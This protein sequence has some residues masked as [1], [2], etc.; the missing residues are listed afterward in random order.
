MKEL[1]TFDDTLAECGNGGLGCEVCKPVIHNALAS[2]WNEPV[3]KK[4]HRPL[5][6]SNDRYLANTQRGGSY[7]VIPRIPGGEILPHQLVAL[8]QVADKYGLY[9]K[10]S[11]AQRVVLFGAAVH[12]LPDIWKD[13]IDAGFESGHAYAKALRAVKS[14]VGSTWCRYGIG[15]SVGFAIRV[16]ERYRGIRSPHKFKGGVSGCTREC[17]EAQGKD[18]GMIAV[19]NGYNLYVCGNGGAKPRHADLLAESID[20]DYCIK[21]LD[22]FLMYYILT[23]DKLQR[24]SVWLEKLEGGL[25]H[26]KDVVVHDKLGLCAELEERMSFLVNTYE[27]EWKATIEDAEK[28]KSF[29]Q[30]V[31]SD[32]TERGIEFIEERGQRRPADWPEPAKAR[33]WKVER[34]DLEAEGGDKQQSPTPPSSQAGSPPTSPPR[35]RPVQIELENELG[36]SKFTWTLSWVDVGAVGDFVPGGGAAVLVSKS[37]LAVYNVADKWFCCQNFSPKN[38]TFAMSRGIVGDKKGVPSVADPV[39]K[40]VFSLA[41]GEC[42]NEPGEFSVLTFRAKEK[43]GRV[44]LELPAAAELDEVL[45][46]MKNEI[47]FEEASSEKSGGLIK[48]LDDQDF[49][50]K[51]TAFPEAMKA[52]DGCCGGS[53]SGEIEYEEASSCCGGNKSVADW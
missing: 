21:L 25:Q 31:N 37:Q 41:T 23:A 33:P 8:G 17:A 26:L 11:G 3:T 27:C 30:F 50:E 44:L 43:S 46:T 32:K 34:T 40:T 6:D 22:R 9:T 52:P 1:K 5:L 19:K 14:C 42:I 13:L 35:S 38:R 2:L 39:H 49:K 15:D 51:G 20:E 4:Q 7:S 47:K 36:Q 45:S 24:T 10:I 12:Q 53:S 29:R 28:V 16:E 18:F 48:K